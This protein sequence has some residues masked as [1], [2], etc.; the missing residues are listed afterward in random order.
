MTELTEFF[1]AEALLCYYL[2]GGLARWLKARGEH[3][4]ADK[5]DEL[6]TASGDLLS[7]FAGVFGM[8]PPKITAETSSYIFS[9][10]RSR[11][12]GTS[13]GGSSGIGASA[14]KYLSFSES[15]FSS[16]E[17][18]S[19]SQ[20]ETSFSSLTTSFSRRETSFSFLTTSFSLLTGSFVLSTNSFHYE[21]SSFTKGSFSYEYEYENGSFYRTSFDLGAKPSASAVILPEIEETAEEKIIRNISSCPLNRFGY[22][23]NIV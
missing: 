11:G 13:F 23:I 17:A 2:G 16:Y 10:E 21:T 8:P 15:G 1:D 20:R 3:S 4:I 5:L 19:F 7:R 22:G 18:T 14:G 12:S 9:S 6:D